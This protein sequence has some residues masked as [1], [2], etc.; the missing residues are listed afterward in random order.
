MKFGDVLKGLSP[1]FLRGENVEIQDLSYDSRR[2]RPGSLF[3]AVKGKNFDGNRFVKEA[4]ERGAVAVVSSEPAPEGDLAWA[5]VVDVRKAM[6]IASCNFYLHPSRQLKVVGVTGTNG[7][8]T[9]VQLSAEI[10]RGGYISTVGNWFGEKAPSVLTT[11]E[12]PDIQYMLRKM[13]EKG[14]KYASI[15]ASSHGL[16]FHRLDGIDFD[17]CVFTNLSGDHLDF[18][19]S[20]DRYFQAKALLFKMVEGPEKWAIINIDDPYGKRL[21]E[22]VNCGVLTY[23]MDK[24]ASIYPLEAEVSVEGIR[25]LVRTPVGEIRVQSPMTGRFNL[26]NIMAAIGVGIVLK[27]SPEEIEEGI[28]RFKGV[29]G[30]MERFFFRGIT[31][32]VDYAHSDDALRKLLQAARE[33]SRGRLILVFGAGGDRDRSKRPRMGRVAGELADIIIITSDNPRTEDPLKIIR[34]VEEG[35]REKTGLYVKIPDRREA[36]F[37]ALDLAKQG[38][39]VIIAG[40]GHEDYQIIGKEKRHFSDQEVVQE[41]FRRKD[42]AE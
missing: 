13:V 5:Q 29:K 23:S 25:A 17:V 32:I 19:L 42:E 21:L 20:M 8:T 34:E 30:R 2:L 6:A 9:V 16:Y 22:M 14:F 3:F 15:E 24:G 1:L 26:Y 12:S 38:D 11:P 41:Y 18:H 40:K 31:V 36:I 4:V 39:T 35:V 7:K 28:K 37:K 27:K 33:I 10:L